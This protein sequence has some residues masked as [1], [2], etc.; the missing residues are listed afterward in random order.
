[1]NNPNIIIAGGGTGG[2]LFPAIAIG[3]EIR[4]KMPDA[5]IHYI[6][7]VYGLESRVFPI[8]DLVH[9]LLPIKG[10]QRG[11]SVKGLLKNF[12]LPF[13]I[14]SSI[15][16]VRSLYKD[17]KPS[18]IIGTGGYASAVPL[19][20][21][22]RLNPKIPILLQEQNSYPGLT[23]RIFANKAKKICVAFD[24]NNF[25]YKQKIE[26]T[27]N[28]IRNNINS[29]NKNKAYKDLQLNK[30][31][32]TLFIF[33]GSQGSS[34]LNKSIESIIN[35]LKNSNT[36]ILWQTG[37]NEFLKYKKYNSETT[38]VVSFINDMAN[39]YS[40]ADLIVCRSGAITLSEI[41]TCG[42]PSIL[43]PFAAAAENHQ[44]K[45]AKKLLDAGASSLIEEKDLISN[46]LYKKINS[47]LNDKERLKKMSLA[48]RKLSKPN[49]A[50]N[51]AKLSLEIGFNV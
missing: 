14:I 2:H 32:N 39:A 36:Q 17:I 21:A 35:N 18:L 33:G 8:K 22:S 25:N 44:L 41:T 20:V 4:N 23:T 42:K 7:S 12:I 43:I 45:N 31:K 30:N 37:T 24:Y 49:A 28:P 27:G 40:I 50:T 19:F 3:E 16:K 13:R 34:F 1:M 11:L 5:N 29:G 47:L 15:L 10:L 38:K 9:T 48:A 46:I 6:G 51:I 26:L